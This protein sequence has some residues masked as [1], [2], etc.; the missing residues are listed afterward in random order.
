MMENT[1]LARLSAN[2]FGDWTRVFVC[3]CACMCVC[4]CVCTLTDRI[5]AS[6]G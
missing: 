5:G 1:G 2:L 3:V 6:L 4:V